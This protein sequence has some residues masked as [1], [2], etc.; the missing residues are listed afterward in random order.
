[1]IEFYNSVD[2]QSKIVIAGK[3]VEKVNSYKY[4]GTVIDDK[5]SW[6]ENTKLGSKAQNGYIY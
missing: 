4:L 1:M 5:L 3:E 2:I 6:V